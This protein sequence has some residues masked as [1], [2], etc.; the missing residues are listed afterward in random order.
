MFHYTCIVNPI[1][2]KGG[3]KKHLPHLLSVLREHGS[4]YRVLFTRYPGHGVDIAKKYQRSTDIIVCFGGDGTLN[5]ILQG[6]IDSSASVFIFPSGTGNDIA[7]SFGITPQN[8]TEILLRGIT[9]RVPIARVNNK[10]FLGVASCGFD[11]YVNAIAN[12]FPSFLKGRKIVYLLA[13]LLSCFAY[14]APTMHVC[15]DKKRIQG[16]YLLM[17]V[18]HGD[19]YGGGMRI[20][21]R[22]KRDD[23]FLDVCLIRDVNRFRLLTKLPL[24]MNGKHIV[25]PE[26]Y[27]SK[28]KHVSIEG[29]ETIFAD[30][31]YRTKAPATYSISDSTIRMILPTIIDSIPNSVPSHVG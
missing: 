28:A 26:V 8:A 9:K 1:A 12:N 30:G 17:A 31:E 5:E 13:I 25:L 6:Q 22:A 29:N 11:T 15:L 21:P 14:R 16:T 2:G 3:Y 24:L 7:S 19:R 23:T 27:Y 4:S 10:P 20:T 18:G